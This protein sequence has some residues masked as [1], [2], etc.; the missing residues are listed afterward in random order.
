MIRQNDNWWARQGNTLEG[1]FLSHLVLAQ[2]SEAERR[3]QRIRM[4]LLNGN[5]SRISI[6][7]AKLV[8]ESWSRTE[9]EAPGIRKAKAFLHVMRNIPIPEIEGQLIMGSPVAFHGAIEIDPEYYTGWL[10]AK[11]PGRNRTELRNIPVRQVAPAEISRKDLRLLEKE[12]L[13]YWKN[14]YLGHWVWKDLQVCVPE[15]AA[16]IRDSQ[17]FMANFGKGFSHTIQ[18][19]RSVVQKGLTGLKAELLRY[20]SCAPIRKAMEICADAL[21]HY[22]WRCADIC[23]QAAR[24]ARGIRR[25]ELE[26]MARICRK[27]PAHP[28]ESWWEALQAIH[29]AHMATFL[30]DGG[31]SHSM[32]RMDYYLA[33]FYRRFVTMRGGIGRA[34]AQ[35]LLE[36]FFLKFYEYQSIRDERTAR[37][38]A[39]DRT[40]DKITIGGIDHHGRD[41]TNE[42]SYRLLEA[43]AHVHLKEPNL[44]IRVHPRSPKTLLM[45]ALEVLRLG[46]GLPQ[47]LNDRAIIPSLRTR[48]GMTLADARQ[49]A[50]IGCQENSVDSNSSPRHSDANGHNNTGYF[51][52]VKVLEL[53]LNNGINPKNSQQ[54]GPRSGNCSRLNTMKAFQVAFQKQFRCAVGHNVEM[55]RWVEKHHARTYPNPFMNLMHPG[56]RQTGLDFVGGGCRYNWAGA[57]G[58]GLATV[59]D[60]LMVIE[61]L[62]FKRRTCS[63]PEMLAALQSNWRGAGGLRK[64]ALQLPRYGACG[65]R[66]EEWAVWLAEMFCREFGRHALRRGNRRTPFVTGLFS[67]GIYLSLG[68][69]VGATPDGRFD[70]EML[71]G[72]VAPS[73]YAAPLGYTAT[74]NAASRIAGT[75]FPNGIVFNQ[76]MPANLVAS[77]ADLVKWLA[78]IRTYFELGGVSVQYS[79]VNRSD[80]QKAQERPT[81]FT[82]LIVRVGGYSARFIDLSREI[83]DEFIKRSC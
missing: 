18:D 16:Y 37:G 3:V 4:N 44:S 49:Y 39:G 36:C 28:S 63:L 19:Y 17:V 65:K 45:A 1:E 34:K 58:V 6:H 70:R 54:V 11:V 82:D 60:S 2:D 46:S 69:D 9:G 22:A 73:Q 74:H 52:L 27:V 67:M 75:R 76:L 32:G 7:R 62:V 26:T 29:F 15:S 80:L 40:N 30:C 20:S 77:R 31:V 51:N 56:T 72:S 13:P 53:T 59:A 64:L 12:I 24:S 33:P 68:R 50:D 14:R 35:E 8:T 83:Q 23:K 42:L 5:R 81:D 43:H 55:N 78:L 10:L 61:E 41:V 47:L 25:R 57:V 38:L 21:I 79:V 71:S 48:I 66:A